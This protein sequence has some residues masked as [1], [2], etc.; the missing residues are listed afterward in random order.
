MARIDRYETVTGLFGLGTSYKYAVQRD[1]GNDYRTFS[2][3]EENAANSYFH[4]LQALDNQEKANRLQE[5]N[6]KIQQEK[7]K[8]QQANANNSHFGFNRNFP[9]Q[10]PRTHY[11]PE[12]AEFQ[13]W[14]KENDPDY[15]KFKKEKAQ[16]EAWAKAAEAARRK[17]EELRN[18]KEQ[19][20]GTIAAAKRLLTEAKQQ[21]QSKTLA[22]AQDEIAEIELLV[23]KGTLPDSLKA[24]E[25]LT[26]QNYWQ[27]K[28]GKTRASLSNFDADKEAEKQEKKWKREAK[29]LEEQRRQETQ[30]NI[31]TTTSTEGGPN[32]LACVIGVNCIFGGICAFIAGRSHSGIIGTVLIVIGVIALMAGLSNSSK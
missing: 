19:E 28:K 24:I 22:K 23:Q 14:K 5:E 31:Q 13:K 3:E 29:I 30:L 4:T 20:Q 32:V 6:L 25:M 11:D 9:P 1:N 18:Q 15:I 27:L 21:T 26:Q 10:P 7:L 16:K 8:V 12:Y 17:D 2:E